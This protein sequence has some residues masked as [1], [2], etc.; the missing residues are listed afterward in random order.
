M[1]SFWSSRSI[2]ARLTRMNVLVTATA[3]LLAFASFFT[4]DLLSF[5]Q[6]LINGLMTEGEIIG[7]NSVSALMFDDQQAAEST[8]G[9]LKNSSDVLSAAVVR[10]SGDP[11]AT[12]A[13]SGAE[14]VEFAQRL[15]PG[16]KTGRWTEGGNILVASRI[17]FD[18]KTLG[19]VYI[20]AETRDVFVRARR[21]GLISAAILMLC[22]AGALLVTSNI[23]RLL[24]GPLIGLARA[25]RI[26]T[27][28][29]DYSIRAEETGEVEEIATLVN[30]FNEMLGQIEERDRA[31][32]Q[33]KGELELRVRE[34]TAELT[35]AN[36]ELEAFSYSVAHDLRGPLDAIGNIGFLLETSPA[37]GADEAAQGLVGDLMEG[38]RRMSSLIDDLLNLSRATSA[39]LH[40]SLIDLSEMAWKVVK[41][42][43][44]SEPG[45]AVEFRIAPMAKVIA[46]ESLM[47][48]VLGNLLRNA[49]KYSS[50]VSKAKIEFGLFS[51][52]ETC[53]YYVRDNGAGFDPRFADRLFQPFQRLHAQSEFPGTGIGLATVQRIVARHGGRVWAEGEV[54][55]G[56]TVFFTLTA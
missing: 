21:Y 8:L 56:A 36:K 29:K 15:G 12:Y 30:S 37:L 39:P 11:F 7:A 18:G 33:A 26:V 51:E 2:T 13:R 1:S 43:K 6:N 24:A 55:R 9:A 31:L 40:T 47:R 44:D 53:V 34:R 25:A 3:L 50:K 35:A 27:N 32:E 4:Y 19:T 10:G 17:E 54:D 45:R 14:P 28:R 38:T 49:W 42:L 46:D 23:R 48:V 41:E 52:G 5:R 22:L 16:E 20:L